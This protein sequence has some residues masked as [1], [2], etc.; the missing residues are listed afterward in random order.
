MPAQA[1]RDSN[2]DAA[3]GDVT[4][5][6]SESHASW[7]FFTPDRAFKLLKPVAFPFL[8]FSDRAARIEATDREFELNRRFSPDVYR[9]TIDVHEGDELVDRMIVMRRLPASRRLSALAHDD[10]FFD[11]LRSVART[12]ARLHAAEEPISSAPMATCAAVRANWTDNFGAIEPHVGSIVDR[13][14]H[15]RMRDLALGYL[16]HREQLFDHRI[17][18]GFIRDGHGDLTADDIFCMPDGPRILDCLA[19]SDD[20]RIGDVLNDIAFLVM[21]VHRLASRRAAISLMTWYQEF[22]NAHH[23]SSLAHHYVAYRAH[24]RAKV[25][26]LRV[27]QGDRTSAD[28]VQTYIGLALHHLERARVRMILVGGGPGVGKSTLAQALCEHFGY[29]HLATDEIRKDLT[30][31]PRDEHRFAE[32]GQG[33][34]SAE[35]VDATYAEQL[36]EAEMLI[37]MGEGVVLDASWTHASHRANALEAAHRCGA[38]VVE[39]ECT[40]DA[41]VARERV[42]RRLANPW[43]PSDATPDI[44]DH[45]AAER[46][47]WPTALGLP[48]VEHRDVVRGRAVAHITERPVTSPRSSSS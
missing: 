36:R 17:D 1:D 41:S 27:A 14:D 28:L 19:F 46:D 9:G 34:Y 40:L 44:V 11:C 29:V 26:C 37:R 45:L 3:A 20:L 39:L 24:V 42:A 4:A 12:V 31:T 18:H 13:D 47:P 5:G 8:D 25:A 23:P 30:G 43:N 35:L 21:D 32:P 15:I 7:V 22:S 16:A 10:D 38:E 33:I 48:T 2:D 6:V